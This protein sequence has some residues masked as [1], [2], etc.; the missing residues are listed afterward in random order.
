[1]AE[2]ELD[3]QFD[4]NSQ[5][6]SADR[7]IAMNPSGSI[8]MYQNEEGEGEECPG[9]VCPME[10][11]EGDGDRDG[12]GE[13]EEEMYERMMVAKPDSLPTPWTTYLM[14]VVLV[15]VILALAYFGYRYFMCKE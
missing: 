1:M 6:V 12:E 14:Y 15:L 9:G 7:M 11:Y 3:E 2:Y 5:E 10:G 8:E 13:G 4:M